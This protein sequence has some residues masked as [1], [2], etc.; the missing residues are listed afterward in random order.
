MS[1]KIGIEAAHVIPLALWNE[2]FL[3]VLRSGENNMEYKGTNGHFRTRGRLPVKLDTG[4]RK[5][6]TLVLLITVSTLYTNADDWM[7]AANDAQRSSWVRT[8]SKISVQ[9]FR[10]PAFGLVWKL[11]PENTAR[12]LNSLMPGALLDFYIGYRGF[13]ALGFFAGSSNRMIAIDTE[14]GRLEWQKDFSGG[15]STRDASGTCPGGITVG[16]TRPTTTAYP[17]SL[18][19]RRSGRGTPAKSGVGLPD[20]GAVTLKHAPP[21]RPAPAPT[22]ARRPAGP[23]AA[24]PFAPH[25]QW[26][27]VLGGDGYLHSMW[28]SNGH[29]PQAPMRFLPPGADARG[30][31]VFDQTAYVAT[32]HHCGGVEDGVWSLS[33]ETAQVNHWKPQNGSIAGSVGAAVGPDGTLYAATTAGELVALTPKTLVLK[34]TQKVTGVKFTSSPVVFQLNNRDVISVAASDGRLYLFDAALTGGSLARSAVYSEPDF[35]AGSLTT[36]VDSEGTRWLLSAAEGNAPQALLGG[37]H[38]DTRHG[39]VVAWKLVA[40]ANNTEFQPGWVSPDL[41]SPIAPVVENGVVFALSSGESRSHKA[42]VPVSQ[43]VKD[44]TPAILYALDGETGK[45]L[46]NSGR[47]ISSFVHSCSLVGGETRLYLADYE[48]NQYAFGIPIE[49]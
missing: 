5:V 45:E 26:L 40:N 33:L 36:W 3:R 22:P 20:Q 11:K 21:R 37:T 19:G 24:S 48:G 2:E 7:T 38:N 27:M 9:A 32:T 43:L 16:A 44:S 15:G 8:D 12:Q 30:L 41:I 28:V 1:A 34:A 18:G 10:K 29:E 23:P 4:A 14:L 39:A 31:I 6:V 49:H 25:V 42:D 47:T 35:D 13:R 46:W 17:S